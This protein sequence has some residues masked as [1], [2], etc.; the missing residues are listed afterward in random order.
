MPAR[1][2]S[3]G[4]EVGLIAAPLICAIHAYLNW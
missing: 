3:L 2:R 4:L 1:L